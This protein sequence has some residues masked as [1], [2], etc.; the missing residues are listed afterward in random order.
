MLTRWDPF[1]EL[2]TL[3]NAV[4]RMFDTSLIP[5]SGSPQSITWGLAL[6]VV[7]KEDEF[8][9]KASVPGIN[10]D[11]LDITFT[12]NVLTIKG[13][14]KSEDEKDEGAYHLRE[15]RYGSFSRSISLGS[16][17]TADKIQ[18]NYENGVLTLHLPKAEEVK[19]KRISIKPSRMIEGKV[20]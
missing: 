17:I 11:D 2:I 6:D 20:K 16:H 10:P 1:Q 8:L 4:D 5:S 19:P 15:R 13:E 7:E 12:D 9:V 18:A 14:T 3:R